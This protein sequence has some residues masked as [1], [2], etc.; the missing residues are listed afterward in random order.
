MAIT[1]RYEIG[2]GLLV[3]G[4]VGL[5]AYMA[6]QVGVLRGLAT[7]SIEVTA[8]M[9][10]VAGLNEGAAVSIAGVPIGRVEH[11]EADFDH[12]K[13]TMGIDTRAQVRK[14]VL[15]MMRA[16]SVLGEKYL[17]IVPASRDA[18]LLVS[19]DILTNTRS[20]VEIDQ[21]VTQLGPVV[22]AIDPETLQRVVQSLADALNEDP[23]RPKRMLADA[24]H[25]LHNLALLSDDLPALLA[26]SRG[27]LAS[28]K[29]TSDAARPVLARADTMV[30]RMDDLVASVPPE[31]LP[32]LLEEVEGA[33]KE[34]RA[35]I[36]KLDEGTGQVNELLNKANA[37]THEDILR[38]TQ[39]QGVLIRLRSRKA[40]DV[41]EEEIAREAEEKPAARK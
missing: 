18:P 13:I 15:V 4:A 19:G 31:R 23:E 14:D 25:A 30:A 9:D 33:I 6:L 37:I 29:R 27:T 28:V 35:V 26:D 3:I 22:D 21:L 8:I 1:K 17:E 7:D 41:L 32:A 11:L 2:V 16:R 24:E 38:I 39:E 10:N 5:L 34:G 40:V 20:A 36:V 12:A